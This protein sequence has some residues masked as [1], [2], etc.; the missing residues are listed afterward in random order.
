M[1]ERRNVLK[2][3]SFEEREWIDPWRDRR[4]MTDDEVLVTAYDAFLNKLVVTYGVYG[5]GINGRGNILCI[6]SYGWN[7]P[8]VLAWMPKP[9]PYNPAEE[10]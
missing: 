5:N 3:A 6:P 7:I 2:V 9:E 4:P 10:E 1:D 8:N